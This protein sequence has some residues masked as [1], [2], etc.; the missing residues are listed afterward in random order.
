MTGCVFLGLAGQRVRGQQDER[1]QIICEGEGRQRGV[2]GDWWGGGGSPGQGAA[3]PAAAG[4][5]S[6]PCADE[7]RHGQSTE[8]LQGYVGYWWPAPSR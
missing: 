1:L 2:S 3:T 6:G 4:E 5:G 7:G 8:G